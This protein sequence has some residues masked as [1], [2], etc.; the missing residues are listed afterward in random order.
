MAIK[1]DF[2]LYCALVL[3]Q[4]E[5]I[6]FPFRISFKRGISVTVKAF[7]KVV[8]AVFSQ[9]FSCDPYSMLMFRNYFL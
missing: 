4:N 2:E 9:P 6:F 7:H 1:E 5:A 3:K 8:I